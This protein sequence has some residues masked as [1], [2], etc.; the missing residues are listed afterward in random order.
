[1][2][3]LHVC[4]QINGVPIPVISIAVIGVVKVTVT[5]WPLFIY[6]ASCNVVQR[7]Q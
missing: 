2:D 4:M 6:T 7:K 5:R 3:F 1:M